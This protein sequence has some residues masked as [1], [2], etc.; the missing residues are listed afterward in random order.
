MRTA[1]SLERARTLLRLS[2]PADAERELRGVLAAEPE[3]ETAHCLLAL[4]LI[5][6]GKAGEAAEEA[7]EGVRLAPGHWFPHYVAGQVHYRSGR[8]DDAVRAGETALAHAPEQAAVWELLARAHSAAGR[9]RQMA[10][11]ARGGLAVDPEDAD[12][13]SLLSI[14]HTCLGEAEP[15]RTTAAY[16]L[17]IDPEST[18]A[19]LA[20]GRAALAFGDPKAAAGHFREV[21]HL[22][23]GFGPARDLLAEALKQRNPLQRKLSELRRRHRGGL[24]LLL[25]LPAVPPLIAVFVLIALMHWVAWVF[26]AVTVL[27]LARARATRLLFEGAEARVAGLCC[28]LLAAGVATLALGV[29]LGAEAV[30]MAGAAVM[31]LV[32]PVQEAAHTGAPNGRAT[33]YVWTFLLAAAAV[34]AAAAGVPTLA[35]LTVYAALGTIWLAAWVRRATA[36]PPA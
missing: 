18:T 31:A 7:R 27:R 9:W 4:A 35:L 26:E 11:A 24:R 25:L 8:P 19:H 15:A 23:P 16:A 28:A 32:T 1:E 20:A 30:G 6:Q 12:L 21:L 2:R 36:A 13:A 33:L 10:D 17:R 34:V 29:A 22:D 14:A 3:Q 5:G